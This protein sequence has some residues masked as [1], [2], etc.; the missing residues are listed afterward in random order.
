M[1]SLNTANSD[2]GPLA[3]VCILGGSGF[4]GRRLL[5]QIASQGGQSLRVLR[6]RRELAALPGIESIDG[7]ADDP[8]A[9]EKLLRPGAIVINLVNFGNDAEVARSAARALVEACVKARILRLVHISTAVVVGNSASRAIDENTPCDPVTAYEQAKYQVERVLAEEAEG[10]FEL[11]ILRPT[12][13]FGPGGKNLLSLAQRLRK[14]GRLRLYVR[15]CLMGRRRMNLVDVDAV[16][17]AIRF[18]ATFPG[19]LG[20]DL[21]IVSDDDEPVNNYLDLQQE[22]AHRLGLPG[23]MFPIVPLPSWVLHCL[24]RLARRPSR[25]PER[26]YISRRLKD[27]GFEKPRSFSEALD[28]FA[29][30]LTEIRT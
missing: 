27:L 17:A 16:V 12:A 30:S 8:D 22:L 21:Y 28:E 3:T 13:V 15:A 10:A 20:S 23:P 1:N 11:A 2:R 29:A 14:G 6:H 4:V 9:L 7:S 26:R 5:R 18:L 19:R 25:D 24:L